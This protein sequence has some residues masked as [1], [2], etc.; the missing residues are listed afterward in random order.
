MK[1]ESAAARL[2]ILYKRQRD[3]KLTKIPILY[4][5]L[6]NL[7]TKGRRKRLMS[8]LSSEDNGMYTYASL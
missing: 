1:V 7:K 3:A 5:A 8:R 6:L 4:Q 2:V